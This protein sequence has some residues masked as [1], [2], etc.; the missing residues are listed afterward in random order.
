MST[1]QARFKQSPVEN[2]AYVLNYGLFLAPGEYL[3]SVVC[4]VQQNL[5][6]T[7]PPLVVTA[8]VVV[9]ALAPAVPTTASYFVSGGVDQ[10]VYEVQFLATTSSGQILEDIVEYTLAEKL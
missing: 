7:I 3:V 2:L 5:G 4:N 8:P 6:V 9:A 1:F 10:G